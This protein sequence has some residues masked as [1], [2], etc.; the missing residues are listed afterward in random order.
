[1]CFDECSVC[2]GYC[3]SCEQQEAVPDIVASMGKRAE[4]GGEDLQEV[5]KQVHLRPVLLLLL[6]QVLQRH[7]SGSPI[8]IHSFQLCGQL[9]LHPTL[10]G[11]NLSLGHSVAVGR[12]TLLLLPPPS[13]TSFSLSSRDSERMSGWTGMPQIAAA[14]VVVCRAGVGARAV[15]FVHAAHVDFVEQV[16]V[17]TRVLVH[18]VVNLAIA[19]HVAIEVLPYALPF[20]RM[21][22]P[23][24]RL[25]RSPLDSRSLPPPVSGST[26]SSVPLAPG[27]SLKTGLSSSS[28]GIFVSGRGQR[29]KTSAGIPCLVLE[30]R[31]GKQ[32]LR[33]RCE[34]WVRV[35]GFLDGGQTKNQTT[36]PQISDPAKVIRKIDHTGSISIPSTAI[37]WTDNKKMD[38]L[39]YNN[40]SAS[41]AKWRF[42][43][44]VPNSCGQCRMSKKRTPDMSPESRGEMNHDDTGEGGEKT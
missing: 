5:E 39:L 17:Q 34:A 20:G 41:V 35:P 32:T 22:P 14:V 40:R 1:M 9:H 21:L 31:V 27:S 33:L 24:A 42:G 8:F 26:A 7:R 23:L 43:Q 3:M 12:D 15:T 37:Q 10:L 16:F 30:H 19:A 29:E 28:S 4:A 38:G 18:C 44:A 6:G 36:A 13:P 25:L 2:M 11:L